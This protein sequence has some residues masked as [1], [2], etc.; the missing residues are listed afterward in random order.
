[1]IPRRIVLV[2]DAEVV[3]VGTGFGDL[4]TRTDDDRSRAHAA[5][6]EAKKTG[7]G[8]ASVKVDGTPLSIRRWT[9]SRIDAVV[10]AEL[11]EGRAE[12]QD[13]PTAAELVVDVPGAPP[14][15]PFA[16]ELAEAPA[17]RPGS[18]ART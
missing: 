13:G 16:V 10:T 5:G 17:R 6:A 8:G 14:S 12:G 7:V 11:V 3:V 15:D 18:R 1:V 2:A 9:S 4:E